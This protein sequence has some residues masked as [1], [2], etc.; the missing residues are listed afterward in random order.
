VDCRVNRFTD[1]KARC[2]W[3]FALAAN[4]RHVNT[5]DLARSIR[6]CLYGPAVLGAGS[7][8]DKDTVMDELFSDGKRLGRALSPA[9][10]P[11]E[12]PGPNA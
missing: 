11:A 4:L 9:V 6:S 7:V 5:I 3:H 2:M 12:A 1:T 10:S 8:F